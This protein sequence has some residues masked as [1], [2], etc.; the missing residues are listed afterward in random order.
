MHAL[1]RRPGIS[2]IRG[3]G[4]DDW[5]LTLEKKELRSPVTL[6]P[7]DA[8]SGKSRGLLAGSSVFTSNCENRRLFVAGVDGFSFI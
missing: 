1:T 7:S 8:L 3:A 5:R 4:E 2:L 6:K